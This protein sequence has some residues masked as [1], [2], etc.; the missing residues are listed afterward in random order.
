LSAILP[1]FQ[2]VGVGSRPKELIFNISES[3]LSAF[4]KDELIDKYDVYQRLMDYWSETMQDD[5][6][7]IAVSGWKVEINKIKNKKGKETRWTHDLLPKNIGLDKYFSK[8]QEAIN[9]LRREAEKIAQQMQTFEED[10]S[11]EDDLFADARNEAGKITKAEITRRIREIRSN[12][13]F[14][15][16][17]KILQKYL[18]LLEQEAEI[19]GKIKDAETSSD[20]KL[21]VRY[22][23]L[24]GE[25]IKALVVEDKWLKFLYASVKSEMA[26]ISQKL[27]ARTGELVERY[28]VP[29]PK[30]TKE[31]EELSKKVDKH[32]IE[33]GFKW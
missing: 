30:L 4:S 11:G 23:T 26:R 19:N 9:N 7:I 3:L 8:E 28:E 22:K 21:L 15:D 1:V 12:W 20:N 24:T 17:L 31:V 25:E 5:I 14:G 6:Y 13:E 29:L 27:A 18:R 16:E 33:M 2:G 10:N 32:L